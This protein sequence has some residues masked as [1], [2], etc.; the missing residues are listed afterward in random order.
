MKRLI[1]SMILL[2]T[3]WQS[4]C[5]TSDPQIDRAIEGYNK[6]LELNPKNFKAFGNRGIAFHQKGDFD[7]AIKDY[8]K[9]LK[10]DPNDAKAYSSRGLAYY[11]M[12][13]LD[14]AI[15]NLNKAI[16]LNPIDSENYYN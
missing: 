10:L 9:V 1:I 8:N 12:G 3:I 2:L 16:E 4:G 11:E 5:A 15:R 14:N 7:S 6:E 13:D